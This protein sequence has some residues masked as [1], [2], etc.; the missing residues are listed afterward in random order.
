MLGSAAGISKTDVAIED[1]LGD[2]F[3]LDCVN[4]AFSVVIKHSDLPVDGSDMITKR[5]ESV[6]V[7]RFGHEKL[8][9]RRV[10]RELLC[11]F[12]RWEK[13]VDLPDGTAERAEKLFTAINAAF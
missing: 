9:K 10:L 4:V 5:V 7:Q 3:Y 12:D 13:V 1:L 2:E 8:D 11:R 6:L